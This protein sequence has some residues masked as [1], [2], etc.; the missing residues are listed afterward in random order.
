MAAVWQATFTGHTGQQERR[1]AGS[2]LGMRHLAEKRLP[3]NGLP[4]DRIDREA[5]E[6]TR[7]ARPGL[8]VAVY[9]TILLSPRTCL[10]IASDPQAAPHSVG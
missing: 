8:K 10:G 3:P 9:T 7:N 4:T 1:V 2:A 5:R 6:R